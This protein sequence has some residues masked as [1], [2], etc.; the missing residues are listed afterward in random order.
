M[1]VL[2]ITGDKT[3]GPAAPRYE[4]QKSAV[5]ALEVVYWGRGSYF[6][7]IPP[8]HFDVVTVQDPFWRGFFAWGV[9]KKC[10]TKF[11]VQ[12]HTDLHAQPLTRHLMAQVVLRHA[13]SV[14]VVSEKIKSQI[15]HPNVKVLPVYVD[16]NKFKNIV[17][18]PEKNL[19]LWIG[20]FEDEKDPLLALEVAKQIPEAKLIMLG[21]GSLEAELKQKG[22]AEFPG[23]QDT[24]PYLARASVVLCTSK[25]ESWG[26]SIVEALAAG[27]PVVAPDVGI[28]KEAGAVVVPRFN[29]GTA[30]GQVLAEGTRGTLKLSLPTA[31]EWVRA[32]RESLI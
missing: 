8:G 14:R 12:V 10:K 6:P 20:R 9:A 19:I 17:R 11:N 31:D 3:F 4:L 21:K 18:T 24:A 1:R 28:A 23:W 25:H 29:L 30:V 15:K 2:M 7:T 32:W 26:A 5:D 22:G 16:L 27:V 13:D